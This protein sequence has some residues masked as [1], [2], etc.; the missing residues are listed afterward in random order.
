[1]ALPT[2]TTRYESAWMR[3]ATE[4]VKT[5]SPLPFN[6]TTFTAHGAGSVAALAAAADALGF[7]LFWAS[8]TARTAATSTARNAASAATRRHGLAR[9][10][11]AGSP[12]S[13]SASRCSIAS[14]VV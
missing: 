9:N 10:G 12:A 7:G 1:D 4:R 8:T 11:G 3:L 13:S 14:A 2:W 6:T 5:M